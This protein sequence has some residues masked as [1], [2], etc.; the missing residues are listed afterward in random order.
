MKELYKIKLSKKAFYKL[1]YYH[2]H[3]D[4][5]Y[6]ILKS[7]NNPSILFLFSHGNKEGKI[8]T[9]NGWKTSREVLSELI[10][11]YPNMKDIKIVYT[12]CCYGG[13]QPTE[14]INGITIKSLVKTQGLVYYGMPDP[15]I[16][17]GYYYLIYSDVDDFINDALSIR[18]TM[19]ELYGTPYTKEE[20]L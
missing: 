7:F 18:S 4:Y 20:L 16:W 17:G 3:K 14:T 13:L 10:Q 19:S 9:S 5:K 15:K 11:Y 6:L 2:I 12:I 8:L 1:V